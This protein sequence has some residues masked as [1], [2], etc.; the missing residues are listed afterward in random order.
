VTKKMPV[1][2]LDRLTRRATAASEPIVGRRAAMYSARSALAGLLATTATL[3]FVSGFVISSLTHNAVAGGVA[4]VGPMFMALFLALFA[5]YLFRA[6]RTASDHLAPTLG[7]RPRWPL[8]GYLS[9]YH[10]ARAIERQKRWHAQGKW[11]IVPM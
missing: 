1:E 7:F 2:L 10:W 3:V 5:I 8:G 6:G 9:K 11:P 4:L